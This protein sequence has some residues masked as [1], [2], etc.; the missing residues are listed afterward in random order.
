MY[1]LPPVYLPYILD[2]FLSFN[3]A[4]VLLASKPQSVSNLLISCVFSGLDKVMM[5]VT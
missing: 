5:Y 2:V 3:I 4:I 1:T